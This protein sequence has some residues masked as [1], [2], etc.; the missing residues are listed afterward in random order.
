MKT[1]V[2]LKNVTD[3]YKGRTFSLSS[4]IGE[5]KLTHRATCLKSYDYIL[6]CR[7]Q[8]SFSTGEW[9]ETN[10][11]KIVLDQDGE[12]VLQGMKIDYETALNMPSKYNA[13]DN[14]V[15]EKFND[16][17]SK[18]KVKGFE[19]GV[20]A[21]RKKRE[22]EAKESVEALRLSN[23]AYIKQRQAEIYSELLE[24]CTGIPVQKLADDKK[25]I[26]LISENSVLESLKK[27]STR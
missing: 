12:E 22:S 16:I 18:M 9:H 1:E 2:K 11:F 5:G 21:N 8:K 24:L 25:I 20:V 7:V 17:V 4:E 13:S 26:G 27:C 23:I 14:V 10:I 19:E 15:E 6:L 3:F